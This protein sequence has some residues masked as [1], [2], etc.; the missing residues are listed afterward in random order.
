MAKLRSIGW[1]HIEGKIKTRMLSKNTTYAVYIVFL[2]ERIDGLK[3]SNTVIRFLNDQ[4]KHDTS[5][6][7]HLKS[8]ET[9]KLAKRR[10]DGWVELEMGKFYNGHGED[11]DQVE[12]WLTEINN[13]SHAKSGL[14]VEGIEFRPV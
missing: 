11:G 6:D 5:K 12:A 3:S 8:Q 14:I 1:I 9:G 10:A 2:L 13:S 7:E 4:S